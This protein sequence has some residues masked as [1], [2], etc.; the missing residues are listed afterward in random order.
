MNIYIDKFTKYLSDE[1]ELSQNTLDSYQRDIRQFKEHLNLSKDDDVKTVNKTMILTYLMH[2]QKKGRSTSTI[3]RNLASLRAF[4]Q[5]LLNEGIITRDPTINL[6]SPKQEKKIPNIL[7]PKEVEI[8]LQQ[9]DTTT[10]KGLRD[11]TMLELLYA[12]GIRVS[13]LVSLNIEDVNLEM[14]YVYCSKTTSNER[15]IPIGNVAIEYLKKYCSEFRHKLIKK[16]DE[17][18]LFV[19]YHGNR[20]TRQGFWKII[21]SYTKTANINKKITPHTLRHSFAAH[22]LQNGADLKSVQEMLGHSDIS[23]TQIYV[24]VANK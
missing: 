21:K 24:Q 12:A 3:S 23:T 6:Q 7:T 10:T 2:L 13:E 19:N 22:L 20:L 5:Y 18:A 4:F 15:A 17:N 9:P 1:R 16:S 8:L 11:R 14:G